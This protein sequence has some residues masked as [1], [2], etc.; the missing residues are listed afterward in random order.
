M[1]ITTV[2]HF[3]DKA[4]EMFRSKDPILVLRRGEIAGIYFP[5]PV[6]TLPVEMK[7]EMFI[8]LTASIAKR[9][10]QVGMTEEEILED[11]ESFRRGRRQNRR[12][13]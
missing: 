5:Y 13:R 3:R 1:K 4:T 7:R 2:R 12:R 8:T 9:F 11:F 10:K 6:Q